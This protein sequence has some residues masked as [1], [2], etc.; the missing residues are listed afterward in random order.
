MILW[1]SPGATLASFEAFHLL[2][3]KIP[4]KLLFGPNR[5]EQG[6]TGRTGRTAAEQAGPNRDNL[7]S[8]AR[9]SPSGTPAGPTLRNSAIPPPP[10]GHIPPLLPKS[11]LVLEENSLALRPR[12]VILRGSPGATTRASRCI[13]LTVCQ[14]QAKTPLWDTPGCHFRPCLLRLPQRPPAPEE[15]RLLDWCRDIVT[16]HVL[17]ERKFRVRQMYRLPM[18]ALFALFLTLPLLTVLPLGSSAAPALDDGQP[19]AFMSRIIPSSEFSA[20][21]LIAS[22]QRE[23][24]KHPGL[25]SVWFYTSEED[26]QLFVSNTFTSERGFETWAELHRSVSA[27]RWKI[28]RYMAFNGSAVLDMRDEAGGVYRRV[29]S[30]SNFLSIQEDGQFIDIQGMS[31]RAPSSENPIPDLTIFAR[32]RGSLDES[33]GKLIWNRFR[34]VK[35][36]VI[37]VVVQIAPWFIYD[38]E[39]PVFYPFETSTRVP[40]PE[41]AAKLPRLGCI[42]QPRDAAPSC[43]LWVG[44]HPAPH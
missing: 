32:S 19:I 26:G 37:T 13:S 10:N 4:R 30:G 17:T 15:L 28:G 11:L 35:A 40:S 23:A 41:E 27:H 9:N 31:I 5:A 20:E 21:T 22:G 36:R 33:S 6:R 1:G 8:H 39:A 2:I 43:S 29:V 42:G 18:K 44:N 3:A 7:S 24:A 25:L 16:G 34:G 14:N 12:W 38:F